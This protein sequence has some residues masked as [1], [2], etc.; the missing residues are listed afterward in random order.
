MPLVIE[1]FNE[2]AARHGSYVNTLSRGMRVDNGDR[3]IFQDGA[4]S[5]GE[6]KHTE[7]PEDEVQRLGLV[8]RFWKT[9]LDQEVR[10]F[11]SFKN[12]CLQQASAARKYANLPGPP[13]DAADQLKRGQTRIAAIQT[14]LKQLD[15]ELDEATGASEQRERMQAATN[16]RVAQANKVAQEIWNLEPEVATRENPQDDD[17]EVTDSEST[18]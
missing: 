8:R 16:A 5:D 17:T 4:T 15:K 3:F 12:T 18:T 6:R 1:S 14:R 10:E 2:F 9:K 7:P 13:E 11:T